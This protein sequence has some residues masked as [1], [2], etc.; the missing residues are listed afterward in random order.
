MRSNIINIEK[1]I[2]ENAVMRTIRLIQVNLKK[3]MTSYG[4]FACIILT[5]ILLL[6]SPLYYDYEKNN[7]ISIIQ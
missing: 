2:K 3:A 6:T 5:S 1:R 7:D 4:F